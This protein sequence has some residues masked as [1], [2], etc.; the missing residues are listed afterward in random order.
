MIG[1]M[2]VENEY[3]MIQEAYGEPGGRYAKWAA[4]MAVGLNTSVPWIMCKQYDYQPDV[5]RSRNP[6]N[7]LNICT[8][9][10]KVLDQI[11]DTVLAQSWSSLLDA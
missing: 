11:Q 3:G 2:Q 4:D 6:I 7:D 10:D 1:G 5:V 9:V 8:F